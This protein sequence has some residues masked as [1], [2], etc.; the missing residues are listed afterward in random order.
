MP[1]S[2]AKDQR[3][4]SRRNRCHTNNKSTIVC[5][6]DE[7]SSSSGASCQS[8]VAGHGSHFLP[9][10]SPI[11]ALEPHFSSDGECSRSPV[12]LTFSITDSA[13]VPGCSSGNSSSISDQGW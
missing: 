7:A 9:S 2:S 4:R 12:S 8:V 3:R 1:V 6:D 5:A 13:A 11:L 10:D